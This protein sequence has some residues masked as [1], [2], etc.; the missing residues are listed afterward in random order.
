MNLQRRILHLLVLVLPI[1]L[2]PI[3]GCSFR[4]IDK[5]FFVVAIGIDR[6]DKPDKPY[7]V[8]LKL[9]ISTSH[10]EPGQSRKYELL[11][12]QA[13]SVG[14]AITLLS[15]R[16]DKELDFSHARQIVLGESLLRDN[17]EEAIDWLMRGPDIQA[18]AYVSMGKPNAAAILKTNPASERL[19]SNSL[20]LIFGRE[21]N[22][23]PFYLP[24]ILGEFYRRTTDEG[25]SPYVPIIIPD[26]QTYVVNQVALLA[27]KKV[28]VVL[29]PT[30][31]RLLNELTRNQMERSYSFQTG[32]EHYL[33][34]F[35]RFRYSYSFRKTADGKLVHA[36]RLSVS[37]T[38]QQAVG[39]DTHN[40]SSVERKTREHLT[41]DYLDLMKKLQTSGTDPLGFGLRYMAVH[42]QGNGELEEW[43]RLYPDMEF[44][45]DAQIHMLGE[46]FL[47]C[48]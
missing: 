44:T 6:T 2:L 12:E 9:A 40:W 33:L 25:I 18:I 24:M 30:E 22:S 19:P 39:A 38:L 28:Q 45:L 35:R 14:T 5:R 43:K 11:T 32:D 1:G 17:Y 46:G 4:D 26:Q 42:H 36:A 3:S 34:K 15:T 7:R 10:I 16:V 31:T 21:G 8:T 48:K 23:T 27:R 41:A 20:N 13:D 29:T 37:I 47:K